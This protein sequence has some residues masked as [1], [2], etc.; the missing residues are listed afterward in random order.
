MNKNCCDIHFHQYYKKIQETIFIC[1]Y[2]NSNKNLV[3]FHC[4]ITS[5]QVKICIFITTQKGNIDV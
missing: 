5:H 2:Q 1:V 4:E 3:E